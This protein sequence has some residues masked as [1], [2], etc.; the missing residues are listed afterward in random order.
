MAVEI[1]PLSILGGV[2]APPVTSF[3]DTM[4][5]APAQ[6]RNVLAPPSEDWIYLTLGGDTP[7]APTFIPTFTFGN[8]LSGGGFGLSCGFVTYGGT[9]YVMACGI[10]PVVCYVKSPY[11][12]S[13][14][15]FVQCTFDSAAAMIGCIG[16]T[17]FIDTS[18][19]GVGGSN[20]ICHDGYMVDLSPAGVGA[21]G[22]RLQRFNSVANPTSLNAGTALVTNDVIRASFDFTNPAQVTITVA[23][24]GVT[25]YSVVDNSAN[26]MPSSGL[27]FPV[28]A[29]YSLA[30]GAAF[31][32]KNFSCGIGL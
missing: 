23:K 18:G 1:T 12:T 24:N 9:T 26:R 14:T 3:S 30:G 17:N 32:A 13:L 10:C 5:T 28:I 2:S 15:K 22:D 7:T 21:G 20:N 25:Q 16:I 19:T 31:K 8:A 11:Y 27:A 29:I 4:A 6:A